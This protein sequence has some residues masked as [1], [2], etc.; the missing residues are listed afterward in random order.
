MFDS[1]RVRAAIITRASTNFSE[2]KKTF[3][4]LSS[5]NDVRFNQI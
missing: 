3:D 1:T 4:K 5:F 2:Q